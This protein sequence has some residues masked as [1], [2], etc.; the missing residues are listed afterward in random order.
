MPIKG[1]HH[2]GSVDTQRLLD[3]TR[4][5]RLM[6]QMHSIKSPG[7]QYNRPLE[8]RKLVNGPENLHE[9]TGKVTMELRKRRGN[10]NARVSQ[11]LKVDFI[12]NESFLSLSVPELLSSKFKISP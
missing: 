2:G 9:K 10:S 5:Q 6:P 7:G 11:P 4:D 8:G 12:T 1:H 3:G